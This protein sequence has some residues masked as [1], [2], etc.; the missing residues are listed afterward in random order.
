MSEDSK[1]PAI[2]A[3]PLRNVIFKTDDEKVPGLFFLSTN[4]KIRLV[5]FHSVG[6]MP[7]FENIPFVD[8]DL[9]MLDLGLGQHTDSGDLL[10][11]GSVGD[12]TMNVA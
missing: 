1:V 5:G 10:E 2:T 8:Y 7:R 9:Q 12:C 4:S 11:K 3:V 6:G